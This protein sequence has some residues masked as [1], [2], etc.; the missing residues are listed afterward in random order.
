MTT[1]EIDALGDCEYEER[2]I[3]AVRDGGDH[4]ALTRDDG[5]GMTIP[6]VEGV[7]PRV[8][9]VARYYGS[10]VGQ[11]VRGVAI[12]GVVVYYRSPEEER[13]HQ[14][15]QSKRWEEQK[16]RDF[17]TARAGLDAQYT[18]LPEVFR[19][20]LDHFRASRAD[21]RWQFEP[22]EM[23]CCVDAVQI[24]EACRDVAFA[25]QLKQHRIVA[26]IK[27]ATTRDW[28]ANNPVHVLAAFEAINSDLNGYDHKLQRAVLP[29]LFDGHSGNSFGMALRLAYHYLTNP[30]NVFLEHG[31]LTPLVGCDDYGC[32]HPR[33]KGAADAR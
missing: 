15:A 32:R 33:K 12:D 31:A 28:H 23:S 17:E 19:R 13:R 24:A 18:A 1:D 21:W 29:T 20:R 8:G 27:G 2:R 3:A 9:S 26:R 7:I 25:V 16:Q 14:A 30:E 10:G 5:W 4:W 6:K 11:P 22:Y